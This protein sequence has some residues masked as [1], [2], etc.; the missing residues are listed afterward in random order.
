MVTKSMLQKIHFLMDLPDH[1][2]QKIGEI[3]II[4]EYDADHVIYKQDEVQNTF[5]MLIAGKV[6][7][8]S[9]SQKGLTMTLDEVRPG[10]IFG[11][12]A[13]L[14]DSR[15]AFTAVCAKPCTLITLAGPQMRKLFTDD[16]EIG[17]IVMRKLVEMYKMRRDM[18]TQQFLHS[19][20]THPEIQ[21]LDA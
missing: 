13:L 10:R 6:L 19:L 21:K 14:H 8:N 15:G 11:V 20:K 5:Y 16:F 18:H 12:P 1:I 7:L 4:Q 3:A 2:L 17:H 9:T